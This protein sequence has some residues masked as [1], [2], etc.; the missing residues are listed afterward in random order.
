MH[1]THEQARQIDSHLRSNLTKVQWW[2]QDE[3]VAELTDHYI[4]GISERMERGMPFEAALQD[5][6][7]GFGKRAGLERLELNYRM[8]RAKEDRRAMMRLMVSYFGFPRLFISLPLITLLFQVKTIVP[9]FLDYGYPLLLITNGMGL[10]AWLFKNRLAHLGKFQAAAQRLTAPF[11]KA[12]NWGTL[13]FAIE[14]FSSPL[15]TGTSSPYVATF[16]YTISILFSL[17]LTKLEKTY[18]LRRRIVN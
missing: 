11:R 1:L 6:F 18:T 8:L 4:T 7:A 9:S 5:V 3:F 13:V 16:L 2:H 15:L 12:F 14:L 10:L 17:S